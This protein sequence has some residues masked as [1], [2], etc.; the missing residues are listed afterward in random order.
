MLGCSGSDLDKKAKDPQP[1]EYYWFIS[2]DGD[3]KVAK[4][5]AVDPPGEIPARIIHVCYYTNVFKKEP[6]ED[7]IPSLYFGQPASNVISP[8]PSLYD[9]VDGKTWHGRKH[10]VLSDKGWEYWETHLICTGSV[11]AEELQ[12]YEEW[13]SWEKEERA[14]T[15]PSFTGLPMN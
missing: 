14:K 3:Y 5:L 1:G 2:G 11:T 13:K 15:V 4:I 6:G 9:F 10:Y 7:V 12:P 8:F